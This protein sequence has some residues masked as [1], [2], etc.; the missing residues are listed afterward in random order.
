[1]G[2]IIDQCIIRIEEDDTP[3]SLQDKVKIEEKELLIKVLK[4]LN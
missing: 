4:K 2:E 1:M 3:E